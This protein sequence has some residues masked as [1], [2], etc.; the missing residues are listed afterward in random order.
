M[1][2]E[3]QSGGYAL[4]DI[5]PIEPAF[6]DDKELT[7]LRAQAQKH[8]LTM[9]LAHADNGLIWGLVQDG[10]VKLSSQAF[11]QRLPALKS[12]TLRQ[13]WL[14]GEK[15]ELFIWRVDDRW[16]G[17]LIVDQPDKAGWHFDETQIQ[18]GD[19][20]EEG[21]GGFTLVAEGQ[22]GLYHAVPIPLAQI[23]FTPDRRDKHHPLRLTIR[24][25]LD[26]V[27]ADGTLVIA[28]SRLVR[29]SAVSV[30]QEAQHG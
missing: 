27:E 3:I 9:L 18:V 16:Q 15:A 11:P 7:W 28:H 22:E 24:H 26:R 17:R 13:L 19:H 8:G 5:D 29:L 1:K 30:T 2:R 25:Y 10:Q 4:P 12:T 6:A 20:A 23:P 21:N 14:F